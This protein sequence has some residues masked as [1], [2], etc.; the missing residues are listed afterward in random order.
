MRYDYC[1]I[2][3]G[4]VGL[5]TARELLRRCRGASLILLEKETTLACH[6]T[7]HNSG[8]IH[9]GVYYEPGSLKARLCR[10]GNRDTQE[11]CAAQ[12]IPVDMCGKLI[13]ATTAPEVGR[14]ADLRARCLANEIQAD[15]VSGADLRALEPRIAGLAALLIPGSGIVDYRRV[16]LALGKEIRHLGGEI[17]TSAEVRAIGEGQLFAE[18]RLAGG[19]CLQSGQL[20]VCAGLQSDRLARAAGLSVGLRIVPF[21]GEYFQLP[22]EKSSIIR[23]LIYPVP[24]PALPFLGVHL[25]RMIGGEVTVGPNAVLGF[26]REGYGHFSF[27]LRDAADTLSFPG[28]WRMLR[29][30][31]RSAF[32]ELRGSVQR[33]RYLQEC[34]KYCPELKSQDLLPY[35]AGIRAQAL[36]K[37]G[38]LVHDFLFAD[39][40]RTVHVLN[41]PSPAATAAMPIA[42]MIVARALHESPYAAIPI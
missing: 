1:V 3:G 18:I 12:N 28:F 5:A 22:A 17:R 16:A 33:E 34:C 14:L 24:D 42:R 30:H 21:R 32:S 4:I 20:I 6:Q 8:V 35:R 23:H 7:G 36:M 39:T 9:A 31:W 11:F 19:E 40:P 13:V 25:T 2:G 38:T 27:N 41:A 10:E 26:A 37:D 15:D 29:K